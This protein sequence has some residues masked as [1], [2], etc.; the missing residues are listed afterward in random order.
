MT[1][2][3]REY[4]AMDE[5]C[6]TQHTLHMLLLEDAKIIKHVIHIIAF[7]WLTL[8]HLRKSKFTIFNVIGKHNY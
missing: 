6:S 8:H 1:H 3:R 7:V 4:L 2:E 5:K